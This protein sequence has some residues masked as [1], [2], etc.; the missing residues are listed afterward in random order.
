MTPERKLAIIEEAVEALYLATS[1]AEAHLLIEKFNSPRRRLIEEGNKMKPSIQ[2]VY[3][4]SQHDNACDGKS[5]GPCTCGY[6]ELRQQQ[7]QGIMRRI[8]TNVLSRSETEV[9]RL[10]ARGL[11]PDQ[12]AVELDRSV[13]TI[14]MHSLRIRKKLGL[15]GT[16]KGAFILRARD[17]GLLDE[18]R[19]S[20]VIARL[21]EVETSLRILGAAIGRMRELLAQRPER[22][23]QP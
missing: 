1:D 13:R 7:T 11:T 6:S 18:D 14:E 22:N 17:L 8:Q 9:L 21:T 15:K 19:Q 12:V 4:R 5:G 23:G 2:Q 16:S 10:L 3:A 20:R